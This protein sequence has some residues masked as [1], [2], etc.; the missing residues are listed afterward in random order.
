MDE[1]SLSVSIV[2]PASTVFSGHAWAVTVPGAKSPFQVLYNHAPIVSSLDVGVI[3]I[4][5]TA[6]KSEVYAVTSG[7]VEVLEN[8][9]TIVVTDLIPATSLNAASLNNDLSVARE[10]SHDSD[11]PPAERQ[12]ARM[13]VKWIQARLRAITLAGIGG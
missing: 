10:R 9:V 2:T 7:F 12:A 13:E 1:R 11:L 6:G 8:V 4:D 3:V 5:T